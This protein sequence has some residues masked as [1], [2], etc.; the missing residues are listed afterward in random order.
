MFVEPVDNY[1][2]STESEVAENVSHEIILIP[3]S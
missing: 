1:L 3:L 2:K